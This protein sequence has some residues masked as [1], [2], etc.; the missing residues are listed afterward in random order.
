MDINKN[1]AIITGGTSGLGFEIARCLRNSGI[2]ICV[3]GRDIAKLDSAASKLSAIDQRAKVL[4]FQCDVGNEEKVQDLFKFIGESKLKLNMI[5]N[6]AGVGRFSDPDKINRIMIDTV[7][8]ANLIALILMSSYGLKAMGH[9]G[10]K[11]INI[12]STAALV[13]RPKEAVYCAA[14]W[15]ARGFT[16]AIKEATKGGPVKVIAV[17]PGGMNTP[18]WSPDCGLSPDV[19]KF[20]KPFDVAKR[21][22]DIAL[23]DSSSAVTDITINRR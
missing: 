9:D 11:I 8:D 10:G 23:E 17:Y 22:V 3:V 1:I 19:S 13:G 7:F 16:E 14:K 21:I 6:S 20:M 12:M 15:G 2:N 5:F 4:K 18:F